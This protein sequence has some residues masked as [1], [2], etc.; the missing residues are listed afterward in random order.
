MVKRI[1]FDTNAVNGI[2]DMPGLIDEVHDAMARN[3][4]I[5][6]GNPIVTF[7]LDQTSDSARREKLLAVW[8]GFP[9][10]EVLTHG[11]YYGVGL[12]YGQS[13]YGDGSDTGLSLDQA[14]TGGR[15]G[16][17]DAI[18]ATTAAGEADVLVTDDEELKNRALS[19]SAPCE[20][21]TFEQFISYLREPQNGEGGPSVQDE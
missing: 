16:A 10:K 7:E 20:I 12:T 18:I 13:I 1:A 8:N 15:G 17:R 6:I 9:K 4:L 3:R 5:I 2:A 21:W 11:G 14:R 19:S